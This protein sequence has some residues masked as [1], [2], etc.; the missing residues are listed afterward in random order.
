M[1]LKLKYHL[2]LFILLAGILLVTGSCS[3][4][5]NDP[6]IQQAT[7]I[8]DMHVPAG[9]KFETTK[10]L[11]ITVK[12][13]TNQDQPV[14]GMRINILTDYPDNGGVSIVSGVTGQDGIYQL[15]YKV[16]AMYDSLVVGTT[17]IGFP[18]LQKVKISGGTLNLT[19]GGKQEPGKLKSVTYGAANT[20]VGSNIYLMGGYNSLGVPA[21]LEPAND[22]VDNS[23]LQDINATLPEYMPLPTSHPQY[24]D[25]A[26]ETNLV[27]TQACD[28]W[29]TFVSE[30]A[31]YKNVLGYYKYNVNNPPTKPTDVDSIHVIFPN[32]SFLGSGG[33]L[34]SGNRVHLG[35]FAPGTAIGWVLFANGYNNGAI[36]TGMWALYADDQ[37]N[38][39][40]NSAL[41]KHTI[42]LNDLGREKFLL[43]FEDIR[44]DMSTDN[45]FNDAIFY[46]TANP[47]TAVNTTHIPLP[48]YTHPDADGD[49]IPD[50][51]DDFPS[52]PSKA[53]NNF[54]PTA[55]PY[56][57]LAFEDMWPNQGDYDCNDLVL[58][59]RFNQITN[60]A[61][62]VVQIQSTIVLKAM[63]ASMKNGF[64]IQ[65]PVSPS[66]ISQVSGCKINEHYINLNT[67]G[68]EAGQSKATIIVFDNGF[69]IF[70]YPGSGVGVNTTDGAPYVTPY[71]ITLTI[72]FTTP[73]PLSQVG[74]PP[75]NPF[76]IADMDRGREVHMI[77]QPPTDLADGALFGT[78]ADNSAPSQGR[79]Y[80]TS[81]DLP[82]VMDVVAPF[83]YPKESRVITD[84][85]TK[86]IPWGESGGQTYYDWFVNKPG[87][88]NT[89]SVYSH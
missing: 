66:L 89:S 28:V 42:L 27:L 52:D 37:L 79:Y 33:G 1:K 49:G 83:D 16:A 55:N 6:S 17:A 70:P 3:K 12:T 82:W 76:L 31:G 54:Y 38:P 36:S 32:V 53:F 10:P 45:D 64:G 44:R 29:V 46:V 59:Y 50:N 85:F 11:A 61:N 13:L 75:Y 35:I 84:V 86:F 78:G 48:N 71:T 7:S 22:I 63:G 73:V 68:T 57:S 80:T 14:P 21:Y 2:R 15:N 41:R 18:N 58:D 34:T 62:K 43:S 67:N 24:M 26:N 72:D 87:Y 20:A 77:N 9:F 19:L 69:D 23:M 65:L 74:L 5:E 56:G 51:F 81:N 30:G 4:K 60:G 8:F 39:E 88:R 40:G 25:A 47:I